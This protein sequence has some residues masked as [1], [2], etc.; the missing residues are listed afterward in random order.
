MLG[1]A[2]PDVALQGRRNASRRGP[3]VPRRPHS[4]GVDPGASTVRP[5]HAQT[6]GVRLRK[7]G[8]VYSQ[9]P[10]LRNATVVGKNKQQNHMNS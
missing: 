10:V 6:I 9:A 5:W 8:A 1:P 2:D 4:A 7:H 3:L